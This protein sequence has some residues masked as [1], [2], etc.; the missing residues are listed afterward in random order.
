MPG[1]ISVSKIGQSPDGGICV[2]G[3]SVYGNA[4]SFL[5]PS[6]AFFSSSS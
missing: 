3:V 6:G 4:S 5:V 1:D 2:V